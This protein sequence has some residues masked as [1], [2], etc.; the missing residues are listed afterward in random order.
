MDD[1]VC[2]LFNNIFL[3]NDSIEIPLVSGIIKITNNN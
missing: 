3:N 2:L 1:F